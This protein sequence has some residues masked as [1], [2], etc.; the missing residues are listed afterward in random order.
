M[1]T[2]E[3]WDTA[4]TETEDRPMQ[5]P[6]FDE[7]ELRLKCLLIS[8]PDTLSGPDLDAA[9]VFYE[10]AVAFDGAFARSAFIDLAQR[11]RNA[12]ATPSG[13]AALAAEWT[14]WA[15]NCSPAP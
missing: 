4:F 3:S 12:T 10:A 15:L 11:A 2:I 1:A 6:S 7:Q 5:P 14:A 8:A 13:R 9:K